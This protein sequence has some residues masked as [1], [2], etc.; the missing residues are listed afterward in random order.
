MDCLEFADVFDNEATNAGG[1]IFCDDRAT[2]NNLK[3]TGTVVCGNDPNQIVGS[4]VDNGGNIIGEY[5]PPV[6]PLAQLS[7][8]GCQTEKIK[9]IFWCVGRQLVV[10]IQNHLWYRPTLLHDIFCMR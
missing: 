10:V 4:F 5:C 2:P 8:I 1:G 3:L 9:N 6:P 7:H